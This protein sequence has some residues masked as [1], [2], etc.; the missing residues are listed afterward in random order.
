MK[1]NYTPD[2]PQISLMIRQAANHRCTNCGHKDM[3]K[4]RYQLEVHHI[5]AD[6]LNNSHDNLVALCL[7]CHRTFQDF[8]PSSQLCFWSPIWWIRKKQA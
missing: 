1:Q 6:K 3:P 2:W 5:D 7:R 4:T 8:R